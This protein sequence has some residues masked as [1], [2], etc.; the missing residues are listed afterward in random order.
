M[1]LPMLLLSFLKIEPIPNS[2][3]FTSF[4]INYRR[5]ERKT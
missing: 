3:L 4:Q 1:S 2:K 5:L